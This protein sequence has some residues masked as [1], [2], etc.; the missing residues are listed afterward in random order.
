LIDRLICHTARLAT[1]RIVGN[2]GS[3]CSLV[4]AGCCCQVVDEAGHRR[5]R[6][7]VPEVQ[8]VISLDTAE[9]CRSA[10]SRTIVATVALGHNSDR[11][12]ELTWCDDPDWFSKA[13][14]PT[15]TTNQ[16]RSLRD[17]RTASLRRRP[18][19]RL[20][21]GLKLNT[22]PRSSRPSTPEM[23]PHKNAR[24]RLRRLRLRRV[25]APGCRRATHV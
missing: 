14:S 24:A 16:P 22:P 7:F 10:K 25:P 19:T 3:D 17:E 15:A 5:F 18:Q 8:S 12:D 11:R 9:S 23:S 21:R 6:A 4:R 1:T 2:H 20:V 13:V